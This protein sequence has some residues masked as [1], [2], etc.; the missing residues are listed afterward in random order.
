MYER[1]HDKGNKINGL[2]WKRIVNKGQNVGSPIEENSEI[3]NQ[4]DPLCRPVC[5]IIC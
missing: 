3:T 5:I 1:K 2:S 4:G